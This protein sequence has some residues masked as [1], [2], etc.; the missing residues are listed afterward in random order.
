MRR[1]GIIMTAGAALA[2]ALVVPTVASATGKSTTSQQ[3]AEIS[4]QSIGLDDQIEAQ[5]KKGGGKHARDGGK[6]GRH[7]K[8]HDGYRHGRSRHGNH[9][10]YGHHHRGYRYGY[11]GYYGY[12]YYGGGYYR[13]GYGCNYDYPCGGQTYDCTRYRGPDGNPAGD[14]HCRYDARCDCWYHTS[15]RTPEGSQS[16]PAPDQ[17]GQPAPPDQNAQPAPEGQPAPD[18]G[19]APDQGQPAEPAPGNGQ[20]P[21]DQP[22]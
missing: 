18:G 12:P 5:G 3:S 22:Y 20:A 9:H 4:A 14:P 6:H 8:G 16:Q 11:G 1:L 13:G 10:R 7:G 19:M 17:S 15:D 2:L 21:S